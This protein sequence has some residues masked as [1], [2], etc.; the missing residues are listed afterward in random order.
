MSNPLLIKNWTAGGAI[1]A[2][3]FVKF[4]AAETVVQAAAATDAVI[5]ASGEL[6]AAQGERADVQVCGIAYLTAGAATTLGGPAMS[7]A[8]G[9]AIDATASAGSN[10][11]VGGIFLDAAAAAGDIVRVLLAPSVFQG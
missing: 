8:S 10:V 4:S 2:F 1:A 9:R 11:R 3:R 7:D 5:G 6:A